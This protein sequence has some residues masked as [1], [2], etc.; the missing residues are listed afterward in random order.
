MFWSCL[1]ISKP[2]SASDLS[3]A[4]EGVNSIARCAGSFAALTSLKTGLKIAEAPI[5]V[6]IRPVQLR[7]TRLILAVFKTRL[8]AVIQALS[9]RA[10]EVIEY[11]VPHGISRERLGRGEIDAQGS[12][13]QVLR[14]AKK[15]RT[16]PTFPVYRATAL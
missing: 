9:P 5:S 6:I 7:V 4:A 8:V 12:G 2:A 3:I 14:V 10:I 1:G 11:E 13:K 16:K 15:A